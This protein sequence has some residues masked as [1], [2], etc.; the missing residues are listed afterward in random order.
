M[1]ARIPDL[2]HQL[3]AVAQAYQA[4]IMLAANGCEDMQPGNT[5]FPAQELLDTIT[6]AIQ[7]LP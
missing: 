3:E 5:V 2:A 7:V 1:Q 6:S 4:E